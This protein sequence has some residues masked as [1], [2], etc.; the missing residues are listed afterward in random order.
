MDLAASSK[1]GGG[2]EAKRHDMAERLQQAPER[3]SPADL[4]RCG[5]AGLRV[6]ER[7]HVVGGAVSEARED[8]DRRSARRRLHHKVMP[9]L[10]PQ[11]VAIPCC[12][13]RIRGCKWTWERLAA[14]GGGVREARRP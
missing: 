3:R 4:Q 10:I 14:T 9:L 7:R 12:G 2:V 11:D 8:Q 13:I 5:D 1:G 6:A